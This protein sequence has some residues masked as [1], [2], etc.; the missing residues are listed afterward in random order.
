M[1]KIKFIVTFHTDDDAT[2][3]VKY[4]FRT[5]GGEE[6]ENRLQLDE[7]A[8]DTWSGFLTFNNDTTELIYGYEVTRN[9]VTVRGE[10]GDTPHKVD[11]EGE[12][13]SWQLFDKWLDSPFCNYMQS[14]LFKKFYHCETNESYQKVA[15]PHSGADIL[16]FD[17]Q[18]CGLAADETLVLTGD[19][20][21]LGSWEPSRAIRMTNTAFNSWQCTVER[22]SLRNK[23][24]KFKFE[25]KKWIR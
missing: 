23:E 22:A 9:N 25:P 24:L 11:L 1:K 8:P 4:R 6:F 20:D 12:E 3:Q 17:I 2:I 21:E 18:A 19:A 5:T 7:T 10:W 16:F 14:G 13:S 15:L